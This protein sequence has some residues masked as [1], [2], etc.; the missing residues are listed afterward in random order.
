MFI[1]LNSS[2]VVQ[3]ASSHAYPTQEKAKDASKNIFET[4]EEAIAFAE[5]LAKKFRDHKFSLYQLAG[6]VNTVE[7]AVAWDNSA[8]TTKTT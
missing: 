4:K 7:P 2:F 8:A 1:V 5:F 3:L 6:T